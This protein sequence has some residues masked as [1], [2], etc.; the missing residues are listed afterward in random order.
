VVVNTDENMQYADVTTSIVT[1]H[2]LAIGRCVCSARHGSCYT[3][4]ALDRT[5]EMEKNA[6][7]AC[8]VQ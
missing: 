8:A 2:V 5:N 6:L 4:T 3:N 7:C 1:Y